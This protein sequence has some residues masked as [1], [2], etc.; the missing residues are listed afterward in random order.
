MT[1]EEKPNEARRKDEQY[2]KVLPKSSTKI[3]KM[4]L[5]KYMKKSMNIA[6][7]IFEKKI[8]EVGEK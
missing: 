7:E 6:D 4:I 1:Q 3:H 2:A 8:K 5:E